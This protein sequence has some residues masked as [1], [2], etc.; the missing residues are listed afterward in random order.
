MVGL[1]SLLPIAEVVEERQGIFGEETPVDPEGV[2]EGVRA[3]YSE[4][5]IPIS[6]SSRGRDYLCIDLDPAPGHGGPDHRVR[7]RQR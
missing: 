1:G 6:R 3:D 7:G 5:W 4:K 2:G